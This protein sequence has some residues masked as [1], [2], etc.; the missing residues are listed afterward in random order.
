MLGILIPIPTLYCVGTYTYLVR[1]AMALLDY[2]AWLGKFDDCCGAEEVV[3]AWLSSLEPAERQAA[4]CDPPVARTALRQAIVNARERSKAVA[5]DASAGWKYTGAII[6][7]LDR[8]LGVEPL[9]PSGLFGPKGVD[10]HAPR[11]ILKCDTASGKLGITWSSLQGASRVDLLLAN[12]VTHRLNV[13]AECER[14]LPASDQFVTATVAM[15]DLQHEQM[16]DAQEAAAV[17]VEQL[18]ECM[19]LLRGWQAVGAE[20]G[21]AVNVNINCQMGKNRSG[22][23]VA[24]W[25]CIEHGWGLLSAVDHL[26]QVIPYSKHTVVLPRLE[27]LSISRLRGVLSFSR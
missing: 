5:A 4:D 15:R 18:K 9:K 17:W 21:S 22:A 6:R 12:G 14:T 10:L 19:V 3:E 25:L 7:A 8:S 20:S 1:T 2:P 27:T 24:A 16:T 23:V 26:R 13:A 11:E